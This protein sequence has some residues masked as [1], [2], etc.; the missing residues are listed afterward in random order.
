MKEFQYCKVLH[1]CQ[2]L[3]VVVICRQDQILEDLVV[4]KVGSDSQYEI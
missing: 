2:L 3:L 4:R 1:E